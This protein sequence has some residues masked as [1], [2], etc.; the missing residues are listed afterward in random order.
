MPDDIRPI[1]VEI[2]ALTVVMLWVVATVFGF[3]TPSYIMPPSLHVAVGTV[4]GGLFAKG[5]LQRKG[6]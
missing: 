5:L 2:I 6:K 3:F 4:V 1:I